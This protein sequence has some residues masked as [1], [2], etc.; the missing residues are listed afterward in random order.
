MSPTPV[1]RPLL[2]F[3]LLACGTALGLAGTDLV[4][5]AV[6]VLPRELGGTIASAQLVIAAFTAGA[7]QCASGLAVGLT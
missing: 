2:V 6:P 3:S 1:T 7:R 5:P 4:L